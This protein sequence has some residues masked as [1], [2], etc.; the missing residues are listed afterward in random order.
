MRAGRRWMAVLGLKHIITV[1][2]DRSVKR[3]RREWEPGEK[4]I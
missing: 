4:P 3:P 2:L 1:V